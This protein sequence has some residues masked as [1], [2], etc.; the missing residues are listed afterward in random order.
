MES[1]LPPPY[2]IHLTPKAHAGTQKPITISQF[3]KASRHAGQ[4]A[5]V[6]ELPAGTAFVDWLPLDIVHASC[7]GSDKAR[8]QGH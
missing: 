2:S 7:G 6:L 4:A 5:K 3:A 1:L 8:S